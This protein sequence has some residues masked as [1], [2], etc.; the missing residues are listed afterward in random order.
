[1][2][3]GHDARIEMRSFMTDK[4]AADLAWVRTELAKRC[5]HEHYMILKNTETAILKRKMEEDFKEA[6]D[7]TVRYADYRAFKQ[8]ADLFGYTPTGGIPIGGRSK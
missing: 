6:A 1:M 3:F 2:T 7:R 4:T 5:S 8:F